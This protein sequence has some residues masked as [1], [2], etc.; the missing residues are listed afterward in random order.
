M[1][2]ISWLISLSLNRFQVNLSDSMH[3]RLSSKRF[4]R[5]TG[6]FLLSVGIDPR[7]LLIILPSLLHYAV[8]L[9]RYLAIQPESIHSSKVSIAPY[10][11]DN[12][13]S[14]G[15][16]KGHYFHQDLW[17]AQLVYSKRPLRHLDLG[18]RIDGFVS[19]LLV[20]MQVDVVDVRDLV[21]AVDGLRFFRGDMTSSLV[22]LENRKYPS[23][24]SLHVIEHLGLGRYGDKISLDSW[25]LAL[26]N[27]ASII[28]DKGDF[29]LSFPFG[30]PAVEFNSQYIFDHHAIL[31]HLLSI[32]FHLVSFSFVDDYG[33]LVRDISPSSVDSSQYDY[34]CALVHSVFRA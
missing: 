13:L 30:R 2:A 3:M 17:A 25:K 22:A 8:T 33:S 28:T 10:F 26:S 18:S 32:G 4:V 12:L 27:I 6:Q 21:T 5:R 1:S 29:Y 9:V 34:A 11:G 15:V 16:A 19:H 31:D 23:I 20:F 24:S 7:R 14:A